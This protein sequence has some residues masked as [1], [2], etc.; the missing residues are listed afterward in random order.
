MSA[1]HGQYLPPPMPSHGY[2]QQP[3]YA[4]PAP[5]NGFGITALCLALGGLVFGLVPFT[6]FIALILGALAVLFGLLGLGRVAKGTATN[7]TM[8]IVGSVL[9]AV[10]VALGIWGLVIVFNAVD[11]LSESLRS[12]PVSSAPQP[13]AAPAETPTDGVQVAAFGGTSSWETGVEVT[14]S[15]PEA[16]RPSQYA[17]GAD[18]ARNVSFEINVENGSDAPLELATMMIQASFNGQPIEQ[19]FDTTKDIGG[20]PATSVLPGKSATF[21][22]G[23]SL[24]KDPGELQLEIR[25]GFLADRSYF[26]GQI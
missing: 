23:Y 13:G 15:A 4:P 20:T 2:A 25:P 12:A 16:F 19:I 9:G 11:D 17:F 8:S 10:A 21:T 5:R 1:P 7:K 24:D 3:A 18:R 6:G 26:A 14:V 22:V